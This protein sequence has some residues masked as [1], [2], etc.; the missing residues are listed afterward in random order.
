[1]RLIVKR[2]DNLV[3]EARFTRGP[4]YI[5]RQIG[6]Q[7]F[8]PDRAVSRQNTV[9]YTTTDGKWV[10]EDL[11]SA[12]KTY[13]NKQA[14]HKAEI[15]NGD[16]IKIS[17]FEIEVRIDDSD[18]LDAAASLEDTMQAT[19]HATL[20]DPQII[21]RHLEGTESPL[22][23]MQ[24]KR[25]KDFS[26][27]ASA[28]CKCKNTEELTAALL[29]LLF[30]QFRTLHCWVALRKNPAGAMEIAKGRK[31][32]GMTIKLEEL[33][34]EPRINDA[35][36]NQHYILVPRLPM[37]YEGDKDK[38]NSA[39]ITPIICDQ[40]CF[41]VIYADNSLD[42]EHFG[43]SDLDYLILISFTVGA[44]IKNLQ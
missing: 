26:S 16:I 34:L 27:A 41:G 8:L 36:K 32:G 25:A 29:E 14:I 12:N 35:V 33:Y 4:I 20:H 31:V 23:R 28:I 24:S 5:G 10:A 17:D 21:I 1:M 3:N 15:K 38:I 40:Q 22:I 42:H 2:G 44:F 37:Q 7:I 13:L 39:I 11:D 30:R 6:S 19:L 18:K 43:I 9:L